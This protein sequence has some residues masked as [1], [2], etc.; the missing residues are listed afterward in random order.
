MNSYCPTAKHSSLRRFRHGAPAI[1]AV[2]GLAVMA[3]GASAATHQPHRI[4]PHRGGVVHRAWPA[5]NVHGRPTNQMARWLAEQVGPAPQQR[6]AHAVSAAL[7]AAA[8]A[9]APVPF[10]STGPAQ[11]LYLVRSY[12]IPADDPSYARLANLSWTYDSAI[13]AVAFTNSGDFTQAAA[14][15]SQLSALQRTD[16]SIDFAFDTANGQSIPE[17]RTGTI[18]WTGLAAVQYRAG[19]CQ[20]TYDKL[21]YNAAKWIL[22]QQVSDPT[23][24]AYGL[25]R[26]GPDV[27]W[28]ST[29]HNLIARAFLARLRDAVDGTLTYAGHGGDCPGGIAGLNSSDAAAFSQELHRAVALMD[30]AIGNDL[31]VRV[32]PPTVP[33]AGTTP[34]TVGNAG[35]AYFREGIGDDIRPV[36]VQA[37]GALWLLTQNRRHDAEAV[38]NEADQTMVV[39]GRSVALSTSPL[40]Y[41]NTYSAPGPF[42]G[43]MPYTDPAAPNVLW[44][45]GT[46]EM[47]FARDTVG[48]NCCDSGPQLPSTS[49]LQSSVAA[50]ASLSGQGSGLLQADQAVSGNPINE[51]HVWPAAA[52]SAWYLLGGYTG[53]LSQS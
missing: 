40:T 44:M 3:A 45:E 33:N 12:A 22:G 2:A 35:T 15:L 1:L 27:T 4:A 38:I 32:T 14:L 26:G 50:W 17:F 19:T 10:Q 42:T 8:A 47:M 30:A 41:N 21:A 46:L 36:D 31:F 16:G 23:S 34:P 9:V 53:F 13:S 28:V 29:Q 43:Y 49:T 7:R 11:K 48:W 20:T 18:A 51:Y 39:T 25:L 37:F 52:P 5:R 24:P 6:R